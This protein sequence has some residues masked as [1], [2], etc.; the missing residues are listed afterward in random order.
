MMSECTLLCSVG[1]RASGR[2][3]RAEEARLAWHCL[4]GRRG[5]LGCGLRCPGRGLRLGRGILRVAPCVLSR[6]LCVVRS[7]PGGLCPHRRPES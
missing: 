4:S 7:Q 2:P 5:A 1:L 6:L 3:A